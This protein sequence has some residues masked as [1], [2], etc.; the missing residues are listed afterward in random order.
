MPS[1]LRR[2]AAKRGYRPPISASVRESWLIVAGRGAVIN[3]GVG[4]SAGCFSRIALSSCSARILMYAKC[5]LRCGPNAIS[6]SASKIASAGRSSAIAFT[7]LCSGR[8]S[9]VPKPRDRFAGCP[10]APHLA[11]EGPTQDG[12]ASIHRKFLRPEMTVLTTS[13]KTASVPLHKGCFFVTSWTLSR[14][15]ALVPTPSSQNGMRCTCRKQRSSY[16]IPLIARR[17]AAH[18]PGRRSPGKRTRCGARRDCGEKGYAIATGCIEDKT[19]QPRSEG[20][21]DA[22]HRLGNAIDQA[23]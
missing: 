23:K 13:A 16:G 22:Y 21:A 11:H 20:T 2:S 9:L 1:P 17:A 15:D 4:E 8:R 19:S 18:F 10:R 6:R 3:W 12:G 14:A 7:C 5:T